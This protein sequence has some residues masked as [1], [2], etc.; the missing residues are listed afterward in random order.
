[1]SYKETA[2]KPVIFR[3]THRNSD[4]TSPK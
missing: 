1:M 3:I 2:L 4:F